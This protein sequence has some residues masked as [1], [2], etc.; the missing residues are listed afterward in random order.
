MASVPG[1]SCGRSGQVRAR[2]D[3]DSEGLVQPRGR[4]AQA[5][6]AG[7]ASGDQAAGRP[8]RPRAAVSDGADP[9]GGH[10][11]ALHR[12]SRADPR[13]LSD[14]AAFA[15]DPRAPARAGAGY[16]GEDLLQERGRLAR[17][18]AQAQHR[19]AAGLVQQGAGH[20]AAFDRDRRR[21]VGLLARVRGRAVRHRRDRVPGPRLVR[22]EALSARPDGDLRRA[23]H[24]VAVDRDR[25]GSGDPRSIQTARARSA[26]RSPRRS[27]SRPRTR[28]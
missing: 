16:A 20:P 3:A 26:S 24:P 10:R 23:L 8:R 14:V 13:R 15:P 11:R 22:P 12:H 28:R 6:A 2:R 4:S 25:L 19:G 18:L 17:R 21:T 5:S 7:A 9:P 27:R 1:G